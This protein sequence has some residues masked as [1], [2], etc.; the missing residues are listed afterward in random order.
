MRESGIEVIGAVPWGTHFCQ[1]YTTKQDLIDILVPYFREGLLANEFCMWITSAPLKVREAK[2]A[3]RQ[4]V[5]D[6]DTRMKAGQIEILDYSDWYTK[7]GSFDAD[8]VLAGW[9][10]KLASAREKGFEGLR[11]TGNTFWLEKG[12]WNDFTRYEETVNRVIGGHRMIAIC[13]YSLAK[14]GAKEIVDVIDNHQ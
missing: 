8:R 9:I 7:G 10:D 14:C 4:V 2:R 3:L 11:L 5:P 13:T 12:D 1:F 6:L